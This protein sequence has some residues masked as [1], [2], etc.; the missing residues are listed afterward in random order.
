MPKDKDIEIMIQALTMTIAIHE[1]EEAFFR[2]SADVSTSEEARE[3]F[4][5]IADEMNVH[6]MKLETRKIRLIDRLAAL[7]R[8]GLD[9]PPVPV[10]RRRQD[11]RV[12]QNRPKE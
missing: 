1:R 4:L 2:R 3:L 5:E 9:V 10:D 8:T 7:T 12:D 11:R 6:A